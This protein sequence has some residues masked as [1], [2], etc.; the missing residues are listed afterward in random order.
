MSTPAGRDQAPGVR[1]RAVLT[2]EAIVAAGVELVD[3]AGPDALTMRAVAE[4][5]GCGVMSLYRHVADR[6]ALLDLVLE[7]TASEIPSTTT[8]TG[9]WRA[10]AAVLARD[11][12]S[13]LLRRPQ[14]TILLTSRGDRGVGGLPALDRALAIFRSAGL[15]ERQAV[16]AN[17]ALG[18]FV[19]GAAIWDAIGLDGTSGETRQARREAAAAAVRALPEDAFPNVTWARDELFAG[20]RDERFEAGLA[21]LLDGIERRVE[22]AA[23][24]RR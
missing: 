4:R 9:D 22:A 17:H 7:A 5:L 3:A 18:N 8:L 19:A 10:D 11:V 20:S 15:D 2:R 24:A 21:T 13:A 12:R 6:D 14:L 1:T 23:T 16:E